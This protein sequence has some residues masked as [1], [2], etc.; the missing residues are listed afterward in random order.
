MPSDGKNANSAASVTMI[1]VAVSSA[2]AAVLETATPIVVTGAV[3]YAV[4]SPGAANS[5]EWFFRVAP[6]DMR[7]N[8]RR[9]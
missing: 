7:F 4:F 3:L 6:R 2:A 9:H 8:V 5:V 1:G